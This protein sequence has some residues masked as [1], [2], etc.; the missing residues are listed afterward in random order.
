ML[1]TKYLYFF[2]CSAYAAGRTAAAAGARFLCGG[3]GEAN[4]QE[5]G[6]R[7]GEHHVK[8]FN[9][10]LPQTHLIHHITCQ[11]NHSSI[12]IIVIIIA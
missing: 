8:S 11:L 4:G 5:E 7:Q 10:I 1:F 12:V 9:F 3:G 6:A 2:A